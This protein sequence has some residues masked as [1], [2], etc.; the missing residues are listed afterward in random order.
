M[1][2]LRK[3]K[4]KS[5]FE[6]S[7][8]VSRWLTAALCV[9]VVCHVL[10]AWGNTFAVSTTAPGGMVGRGLSTFVGSAVGSGL[11]CLLLGGGQVLLL[12]FLRR[13]MRR[14]GDH[15][16]CVVA[17]WELLVV[18]SAVVKA[19]PGG[20]GRFSYAHTPSAWD[21]FRDTFLANG[22]VL[23]GLTLLVV[24]A[25]CVCLYR[26]RVRWY[27]IA[28]MVCPLLWSAWGVL[29]FRWSTSLAAP[30]TAIL[31]SYFAVQAV[32]AIVPAVLLRR[33][34]STRVDVRPAEGDSDVA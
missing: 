21:S 3:M 32:M 27:G 34:M 16:W 25:L 12:D 24:A 23:S 6:V 18:L 29:C 31:L 26:G 14:L 13:G 33:T 22:A 20:G 10:T 8:A 11:V 4:K 5:Y 9:V 2:K 7:Q 15:S 19:I 1:M 28:A 17:F 30:S